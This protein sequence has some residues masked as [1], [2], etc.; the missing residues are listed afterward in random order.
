MLTLKP[1]GRGNWSTL[2]VA[3]EGKRASPLLIRAG[4]KLTLGGIVYRICSVTP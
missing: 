1:A 4:Q 2:I 3:V